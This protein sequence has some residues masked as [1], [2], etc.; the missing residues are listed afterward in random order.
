MADGAPGATRLSAEWLDWLTGPCAVSFKH[1]R[2]PSDRQQVRL[3]SRTCHVF[4]VLGALVAL[5][6]AV[7]PT[8]T[9]AASVTLP[10]GGVTQVSTA[11]LDDLIG[12]AETG[13]SG[14]QLAALE[15]TL[16]AKLLDE[17]PPLGSLA[18]VEGLGETAGVR[19]ALVHALEEFVDER[20]P[21]GEL[22]G[23]GSELATDIEEQL[24]E[25]FEESGVAEEAGGPESLEEAVERA[26]GKTPEAV[27][28][29]G[30]SSLSLGELL[31]RL[32][33]RASDPARL[34]GRI[35]SAVEEEELDELLGTVPSGEPFGV[36]DVAEAASAVG[37]SPAELA[38]A[39]GQTTSE[40][41]EA[42]PALLTALQDGRALGLFAGSKGLSFALFGPPPAP[43]GEEEPGEG[44]EETTPPLETETT[45]PAPTPG[46]GNAPG[47]GSPVATTSQAPAPS[48]TTPPPAPP[49]AKAAA[50]L[51]IVAHRTKRG[52]LTLTLRIP[53]P[54]RLTVGGADLRTVKRSFTAA[55]ARA[56]VTLTPTHAALVSLQRHGRL[57]VRLAASFRTAGGVVST[58]V[59]AVTLG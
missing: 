44:G 57:R 19:Q 13:T 41:P 33:A 6:L 1:H 2:T 17:L 10:Q 26:L 30:L 16:L 34:A 48:A 54:G 38:Q 49:A 46:A 43:P 50:K 21:L 15:P 45:P 29:E 5:L 27:I 8:A 58:A 18:G 47:G 25:A 14:V 4:A 56:T 53:A 32:L 9:A 11:A 40:L 3:M 37:L 42:A 36:A 12:E 39:L 31:S 35:F 24:E 23:A 52:R 20:Q 59:L 28:G 22:V 7:L 55:A 51:A